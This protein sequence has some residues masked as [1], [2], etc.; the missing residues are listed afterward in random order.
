M[1][2][3]SDRSES[4]QARPEPAEIPAALAADDPIRRREAI[5]A[6]GTLVQS[7]VDEAVEHAETVARHLDDESLIV[8]RGAAEVLAPVASEQPDILLTKLD[9]IVELLAADT[10]DLSVAGARLLSPLAVDRPE[11]V[12][13]HTDRLLEIL[14]DD[15][16]PD[17][18]TTVPESIDRVETRQIVQSVQQESR[19]RRQYVR[20]T[21]A[22]VIVAVAESDPTSIDD[23]ESLET[24]LDDPDPGVVGP[25]LDALG[26]MAQEDAGRVRQ[27]L[28]SVLACLDHENTT[29]R[30]RAVRTLGYLDAVSAV[31]RLERVAATDDDETV[32]ELAAETATFLSEE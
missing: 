7:D 30:A 31:A 23:V 20:Q 9:R 26:N 10:V 21:I 15:A 14:I 27:T 6:F 8:A 2:D 19:K 32:R 5:N 4:S 13:G 1:Q 22:N 11:A 18:E 3:E 16:V 17:P 25:A 12:A 24:L 28:D 29:V